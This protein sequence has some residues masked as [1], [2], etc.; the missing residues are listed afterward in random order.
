MKKLVGVFVVAA[1]L[2]VAFSGTPVNA[3]GATFAPN[4][5][6]WCVILTNF[7]D[8]LQI[9]TDAS[10][11]NYGGWDWVCTGDH[12]T[13]SVLGQNAPPATTGTRPVYAG[14]PFAYTANFIWH[15]GP[16]TFDLWGTNG[17]ATFTFQQNQ[18]FSFTPGTCL[19]GASRSLP[20]TLG[21]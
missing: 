8:T 21:R 7:C 16:M 1:A 14:V 17:A 3:A 6:P 4:G 12:T 5:G 10:A 18:P 20:S 2:A 11:N 13:T 15:V 19:S 9:S